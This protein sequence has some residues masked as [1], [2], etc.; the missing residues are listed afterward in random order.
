MSCDC[1]LDI[2]LKALLNLIVMFG[3]GLSEIVRAAYGFLANNWQEGDKIYIFGFSRGAYVARSVAG[4]V[5]DHGLLTKRGMDNF[6]AVYNTFYSYKFDKKKD[7]NTQNMSNSVEGSDP[8]PDRRLPQ[9][10][11]KGLRE[12]PAKLP[13]VEVLAVF[14]TVA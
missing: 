13:E 6:N 11:F 12:V 9:E 8:P 7:D 5:A 4:L 14:D 2:S 3:T 10:N 1:L